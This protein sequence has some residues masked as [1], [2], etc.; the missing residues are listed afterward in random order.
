MRNPFVAHEYRIKRRP[1][2]AGFAVE[3]ELNNAKLSCI[4]TPD[5]NINEQFL[6]EVG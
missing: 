2:F 3:I 4:I 1:S 5:L 6:L